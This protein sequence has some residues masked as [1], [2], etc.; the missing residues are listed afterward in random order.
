MHPRG[1]SPRP[2]R[3]PEGGQDGVVRNCPHREPEPHRAESG[4]ERGKSLGGKSVEPPPGGPKAV[5]DDARSPR[6]RFRGQRAPLHHLLDE[7]ARHRLQRL[8]RALLGLPG[9]EGVPGGLG[10]KLAREPEKHVLRRAAQRTRGKTGRERAERRHR[11][12]APLSHLLS[13]SLLV[14]APESRASARMSTSGSGVPA[15]RFTR[16]EARPCDGPPP[17][18]ELGASGGRSTAV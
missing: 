9:L 18:A 17:T 3:E 8:L 6:L 12:C 4:G 13:P 7:A 10:S 5:V 15:G 2:R 1:I 14:N 16:Y 11:T